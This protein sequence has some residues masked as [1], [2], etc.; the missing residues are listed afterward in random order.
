MSGE[1]L[2]M[3]TVQNSE[4]K[5]GRWSQDLER[6]IE[7]IEVMELLR[8]NGEFD[9]ED[10]AEMISR[11]MLSEMGRRL[12]SISV[13]PPPPQRR[14]LPAAWLALVAAVA[15]LSAVCAHAVATLRVD[16]GPRAAPT[17]VAAVVAPIAIPA[18]PAPVAAPVAAPAAEPVRNVAT[19][20]RAERAADRG[21]VAEPITPEGAIPDNPYGP[22][23]ETPA[24]A[25]VPVAAS[26]VP[27]RPADP[28]DALV[29]SA[30]AKPDR[31]GASARAPA[32]NDLPDTGVRTLPELPSRTD[33]SRAMDAVAGLVRR[34]GG[35][36]G[37]RLVV[38]IR[39]SGATGRV[40]DAKTVDGQWSGTAAGACAARA[41]RVAKLPRFATSDLVVR[42]PF[43]I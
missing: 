3:T 26:I 28:V 43:D 18:P 11:E 22:E 19:I 38:E 12:E 10:D 17:S 13:A 5:P 6:E 36:A 25:P 21:S 37:G 14:R 34:C 31:G 4:L 33:V 39:V 2:K 41:V 29:G 7:A 35:D 15:V 9:A 16:G 8:A 30:L 32:T 27:A 24:P 1:G 23:T 42:Y 20:Y 40:R